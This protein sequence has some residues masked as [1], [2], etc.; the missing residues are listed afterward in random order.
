MG[1]DFVVTTEDGKELVIE[2]NNPSDSKKRIE[3]YYNALF[4]KDQNEDAH[5]K[6]A[7][8]F[9]VDSMDEDEAIE[10]EKSIVSK[11]TGYSEVVSAGAGDAMKDRLLA[12]MTKFK[13]ITEAQ[14]ELSAPVQEMVEKYKK[15]DFD[16]LVKEEINGNVFTY[17]KDK[18]PIEKYREELAELGNK[19][20]GN[21]WSVSVSGDGRLVIY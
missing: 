3:A 7:I 17:R 18:F 19:S 6:R 20:K 14:K 9:I 11:D 12:Y 21:Q 16:S 15:Y 1:Y 8:E 4:K 13:E 2:M 10:L 5:T